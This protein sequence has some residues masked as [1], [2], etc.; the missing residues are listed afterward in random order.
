[1][2]TSLTN[3][4]PIDSVWDPFKETMRTMYLVENRSLEQVRSKMK[5]VHQFEAT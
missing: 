2:S 4:E 3:G 1:M 5:T